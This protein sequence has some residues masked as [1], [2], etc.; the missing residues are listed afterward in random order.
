MIYPKMLSILSQAYTLPPLRDD[1]ALVPYQIQKFS[2]PAHLAKRQYPIATL[3]WDRNG[4]IKAVFNMQIS[5][6]VAQILGNEGVNLAQ[7]VL[8]AFQSYVTTA[9]G[10]AAGIFR[11]ATWASQL[12]SNWAAIVHQ[13]G[14]EATISV[15]VTIRPPLRSY[16]NT[17]FILQLMQFWFSLTGYVAFQQEVADATRVGNVPGNR[18]ERHSLTERQTIEARSDSKFCKLMIQNWQFVLTPGKSDTLLAPL[19]TC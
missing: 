6:L 9:A 13:F 19:I 5:F 12:G 1:L 10:P 15:L 3:F 8:S 14:G 11:G 17:V 16:Q 2:D 4:N 18:I 7:S